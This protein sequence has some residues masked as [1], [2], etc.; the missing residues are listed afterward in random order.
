MFNSF[1]TY[2]S[3]VVIDLNI[4]VLTVD[5]VMRSLYKAWIDVEV[6]LK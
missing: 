3:C 6:T 2:S 4:E 1:H 5:E